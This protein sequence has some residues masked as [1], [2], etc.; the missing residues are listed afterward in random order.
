MTTDLLDSFTNRMYQTV[1]YI[2][3]TR[4]FYKKK[5]QTVHKA[6]SRHNL[7]MYKAYK[8]NPPL[9]KAGDSAMLSFIIVVH[10]TLVS[11]IF[12]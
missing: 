1:H 8:K 9:F 5:H 2:R 7:L 11:S 12:P 6:N 3:P 10:T 4:H